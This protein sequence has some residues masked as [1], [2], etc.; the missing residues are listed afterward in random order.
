MR[1]VAAIV[2]VTSPPSEPVKVDLAQLW[3]LAADR[4]IVRLRRGAQ[5]Q[6]SEKS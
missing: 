3:E 5:E 2:P 4:R 6:S 1:D